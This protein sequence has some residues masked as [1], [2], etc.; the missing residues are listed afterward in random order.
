MSTSLRQMWAYNDWANRRVL[1]KFAEADESLP[2]AALCLMSHIV[3]AQIIWLS[4]IN[5]ITPLWKT[6]DIHNV[7]DCKELHEQSSK[8][9]R[10]CV[11]ANEDGFTHAINYTNTEGITF[12]NNLQDIL[13]HVFNHGTYHRAQIAMEL[14]R[15]GFE[16]PVTDYIHFLRD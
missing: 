8:G 2:Y 9:L 7:T 3:N 11:D 4:R 13:L 16:P 6:W 5:R 14:R 10:D 12:H 15:S 1:R